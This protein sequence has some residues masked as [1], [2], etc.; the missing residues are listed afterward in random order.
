MIRLSGFTDVGKIREHNEDDYRICC[1]LEQGF[2]GHSQDLYNPLSKSGALMVVADGMGGADAGEI[3]SRLAVEAIKKYFSELTLQDNASDDA[4]KDHLKLAFNR[5]FRAISTAIEINPALYKMGTTLTVAWLMPQGLYIAWIGDSRAYLFNKNGRLNLQ[6]DQYKNCSDR[7]KILTDDH[8]L[9]WQEVIKTNGTFSAEQARISPES[10][11]ILRCLSNE[12]LNDE[13]DLVGPIKIQNNDRIFLCSDGLNG[14]LPDDTV[15]E[16]IAKFEDD[17]NAGNAL[18]DAANQAGGRDNITVLLASIFSPENSHPDII[19]ST[20]IHYNKTGKKR[21]TTQKKWLISV[22]ISLVILGL[23]FFIVYVA[24]KSL[25]TSSSSYDNKPN[26]ILGTND[27]VEKKDSQTIEILDQKYKTNENNKNDLNIKNN[28]SDAANVD[29]LKT[30]IDN[31]SSKS[32]SSIASIPKQPI[33]LK[34]I[35]PEDKDI[36]V[37][38]EKYYKLLNGESC[39]DLKLSI[40]NSAITKIERVK[41][42]NASSNNVYYYNSKDDS[43]KFKNRTACNEAEINELLQSSNNVELTIEFN[44]LRKKGENCQDA[45]IIKILAVSSNKKDIFKKDGRK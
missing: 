31:P 39:K 4:I 28:L 5:A 34:V 14:M 7:L 12:Y 41:S 32:D 45:K 20:T 29:S 37:K 3:A 26:L 27:V 11:I 42:H 8:S 2:W 21:T 16:L 15:E 10:N 1:N 44:I 40:C 33:N 17:L 25:H 30:I 13:P 19:E 43:N 23:L 18:L 38:H 24:N 36:K 22:T 9:V 6:V 35:L